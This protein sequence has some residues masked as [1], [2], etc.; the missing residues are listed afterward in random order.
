MNPDYGFFMRIVIS[1]SEI[2]RVFSL[3]DKLSVLASP[4]PDALEGKRRV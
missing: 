1:E 2:I 4:L 3:F